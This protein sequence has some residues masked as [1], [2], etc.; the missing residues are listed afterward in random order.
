MRVRGS[1]LNRAIHCAQIP[2]SYMVRQQD[3]DLKYIAAFSNPEVRIRTVSDP[4]FEVQNFSL[5]GLG[6]FIFFSHSLSPPPRRTRC[7]GAWRCRSVPYTSS[8]RTHR[9]YTRAWSAGKT[10]DCCSGGRGVDAVWAIGCEQQ[11]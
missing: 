1:G 9:G 3:G 10:G 2:G 5:L 4:V 7:Y 11:G 6:D 8:G